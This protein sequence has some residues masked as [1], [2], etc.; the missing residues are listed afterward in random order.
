MPIVLTLVLFVTTA[1]GG[2]ATQTKSPNLS[3]PGS[4][5]T[6]QQ[7][8]KGNTAA[9]QN[10]GGWII[11]TAHGLVQDAYVRDD[12]KLGAVISPQVKPNEVRPLA[13]SLVQGFH[14]SFPERD[15]AVLMYAPDKQLILTAKYN[16]ATHQIE[17]Q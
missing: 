1:C 10:F 9:G 6:Y 5:A 17:Y 8:E 14:N 4:T 3:L 16:N 15:L 7:L 13:R 12:N 11:Q 2:G